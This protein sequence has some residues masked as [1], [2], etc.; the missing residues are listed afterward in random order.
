MTPL[1]LILNVVGIL[2]VVL[3]VV[4]LFLPLLPTT[5]FLLLA[6][7][8]FMRGSERLH[9]RLLANP[10]CGKLIRD[11]EEHRSIPRR[12]KVL[13]LVTMWLSISL[14]IY[15]VPQPWLRLLLAAIASGVTVYL[16]RLRSTGK[17][18]E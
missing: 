12:A 4:G 1:K 9:R 8:C 10:W 3:G 5:P 15:L 13:A 6:S 7:A 18:G 14:S 17:N 16:L 2:A 11:F